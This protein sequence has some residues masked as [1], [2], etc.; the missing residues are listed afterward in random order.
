MWCNVVGQK[1][2][3]IDM[4]EDFTT[5]LRGRRSVRDGGAP[6]TPSAPE[7][8]LDEGCDRKLRSRRTK[9]LL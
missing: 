4:K 1:L 2:K 8:E 6:G 9:V 5:T 3:L 7:A